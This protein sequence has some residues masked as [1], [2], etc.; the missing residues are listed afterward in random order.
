[1]RSGIVMSATWKEFFNGFLLNGLLH[2]Y[3]SDLI[4][5]VRYLL[6]YS[7]RIA[8]YKQFILNRIEHQ[9]NKQ[10]TAQKLP[11]SESS[12]SIHI[13]KKQRTENSEP[14]S[15][16]QLDNYEDPSLFVEQI[17]N[18]SFHESITSDTETPELSEYEND[19]ES[20]RRKKHR[21]AESFFK[22]TK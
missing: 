2:I 14:G 20:S 12:S 3:K 6:G 17:H 15:S 21:N 1:M 4:R 7:G 9:S 19:E 5:A 22:L 11:I 10:S 13:Q 8:H 18:L 16:G